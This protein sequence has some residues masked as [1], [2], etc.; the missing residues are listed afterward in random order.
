VV[1]VDVAVARGCALYDDG[2]VCCRGAEDLEGS[3]L[4]Q[5]MRPDRPV[6]VPGLP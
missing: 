2:A 5:G 1:D 4:L 3:P 6:E